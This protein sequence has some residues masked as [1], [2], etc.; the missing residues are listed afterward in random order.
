MFSLGLTNGLLGDM[1]GSVHPGLHNTFALWPARCARL[2]LLCGIPA[3][4]RAMS[5]TH[6]CPDAVCWTVCVSCHLVQQWGLATVR[7]L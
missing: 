6:S 3:R 1:G 4:G 5:G 2:D 7:Q